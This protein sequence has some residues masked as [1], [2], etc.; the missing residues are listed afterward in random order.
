MEVFLCKDNMI[1]HV[2]IV[3]VTVRVGVKILTYYIGTKGAIASL[4]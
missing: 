4:I 1:S 3:K 2:H